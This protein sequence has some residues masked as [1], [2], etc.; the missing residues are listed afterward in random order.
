MQYW[1]MKTEPDVFSFDDLKKCANQ[2]EPWDGIRNYQARNFMRDT[3]KKGD[4]VLF[5]HSR[6]TP[7]GIVGIA[8]I[9]SEPYPDHTAWDPES[10]YY[11]PKASPTNPRW[12]MVDVCYKADFK[13]PV[14][15]PQL[16]ETKTLENMKVVQRGQRLSIQPVEKAHF[17]IVCEMGG[18]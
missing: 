4:Q 12:V 2:T 16:K 13:N 15:L 10:N 5:Y 8:E 17:D 18:L 14:T 1:L 3:I 11:D 6:C 7:P 9:A